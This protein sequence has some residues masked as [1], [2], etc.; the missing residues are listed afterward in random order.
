MFHKPADTN[1]ILQ[2]P[3]LAVGKRVAGRKTELKGVSPGLFSL[4][5][6]SPQQ[7]DG[8]AGQSLPPSRRHQSAWMNVLHFRVW[9]PSLNTC[10]GEEKTP[11]VSGY[12]VQSDRETKAC[13]WLD[14][15]YL[16]AINHHFACVPYNSLTEGNVN[17]VILLEPSPLPEY[18]YT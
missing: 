8:E 3:G 18:F 16:D 14:R 17:I 11:C 15:A 13:G 2:A 6:S 12:V 7:A 9:T 10:T 1:T 4:T 5:K